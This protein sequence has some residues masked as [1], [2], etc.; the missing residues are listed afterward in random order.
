MF[1]I[2]KKRLTIENYKGVRDFYPEDKAIQNYIFAKMRQVVESYGYEEYDA[3]I[4]EPLELYKTKS[5]EEILSEQIY[6]FKDRAG[7]EVVLRPEMTPTVARMVGSRWQDL[8]SP[9]RWYSIPNVFRYEKPQKGRLREHWQLN[10]DLFGV[11]GIFSDIEPILIAY[12]IL[13]EFGAEN[14]DF[15]IKVNSRALIDELLT[16]SGIAPDQKVFVYR[17]LD[18][19]EKMEDSDFRKALIALV[20][21]KSAKEILESLYLQEGLLTAML[22]VKV[23]KDLN[24]TL[25]VLRSFGVDNLVFTPTLTRGFDYYT[26]L[27]FEVFDS[28]KENP[29]SIFGGGRYDNLVGVFAGT[30]VPAFGFGMGDVTIRDFLET[31]HLLPKLEPKIDLYLVLAPEVEMVKVEQVAEKLRDYGLKV[32]VDLSFKKLNDQLKSLDKRNVNFVMVLGP[33]ELEADQFIIRHIKTREE[34]TANLAEVANIIF[35]QKNQ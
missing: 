32:A 21:E 6:Q 20:G 17:L 30:D 34:K 3:S 18:K 12:K 33:K 7:R 25:E 16:R 13:K 23:V 11:S 4:L 15:V 29:R 8:K 5:S 19:K 1:G 10:V 31:H 27:V 24:Q 14:K 22:D 2:G 28:N 9:V 26:G 35:S